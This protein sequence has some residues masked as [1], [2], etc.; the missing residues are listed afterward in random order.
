VLKR[1]L[2]GPEDPETLPSQSIAP[3][4]GDLFFL[5]DSTAAVSL[6]P[7][8]RASAVAGPA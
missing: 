8:L 7:G 3:L 6:S 1:V 4:D 5:L 2:E